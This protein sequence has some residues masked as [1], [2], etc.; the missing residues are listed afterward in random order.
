MHFHGIH[1]ARMDGVPGAG[2]VQPGES[3]TYEF[4]AL[5]FGCHLYHCHSLPLKRHIHKGI[6]GAF[7]VDPDPGT[8]S[9]RARGGGEPPPRLAGERALA[10][11]SSW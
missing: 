5:P 2:L 4:D 9:A 3:F 11:D 6:Y 7:I 10:G 1:A 8:A